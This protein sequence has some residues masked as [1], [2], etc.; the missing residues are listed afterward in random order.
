[1]L[2]WAFSHAPTLWDITTKILGSWDKNRPPPPPPKV[3]VVNAVVAIW[4][5]VSSFSFW[6]STATVLKLSGIF[7]DLRHP[8]SIWNK[9]Y[10]GY[11]GIRKPDG[12]FK[13]C[14]SSPKHSKSSVLTKMCYQY[15]TFLNTNAYFWSYLAFFMIWGTPTP[16]R[17]RFI[18]VI[19][20]SENQMNFLNVA[21]FHRNTQNRHF[22]PDRLPIWIFLGNI[23]WI[24]L[25]PSF[26]L[27]AV[28]QSRF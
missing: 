6:A 20:A 8:H 22:G 25:L 1:M 26:K 21:T 10:I 17:I 28:N 13:C 14:R 23:A 15:G 18:L 2:P 11:Y 3:Y 9:I 12:F 5:I 4:A 24:F 7:S 27:Q 16:Y 19:M